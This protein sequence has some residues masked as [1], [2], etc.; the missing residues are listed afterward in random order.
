MAKSL[1]HQAGLPAILNL[2]KA[3]N[4]H[5]LRVRFGCSALLVSTTITPGGTG[6]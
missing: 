5:V 2:G 3:R 4:P 1:A 6:S